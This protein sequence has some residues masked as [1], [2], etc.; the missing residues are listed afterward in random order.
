MQQHYVI[1]WI[2]LTCF[3]HSQAWF[4]DIRFVQI[5]VWKLKWSTKIVQ[6]SFS[7]LYWR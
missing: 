4:E 7:F 5:P 2:R 6:M 3:S 1:L